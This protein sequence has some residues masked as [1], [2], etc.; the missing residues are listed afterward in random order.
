MD[1]SFVELGVHTFVVAG[2][3]IARKLSV[4]TTL[5]GE[6]MLQVDL[7][8]DLFAG[9][10]GWSEGLRMVDPDQIGNAVPPLLAA[11]VLSAVTGAGYGCGTSGQSP[12]H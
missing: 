9:P 11:H 7:I 1:Q 12:H 2:V 5:N 3:L 4:S 10:G 6:G 8:I